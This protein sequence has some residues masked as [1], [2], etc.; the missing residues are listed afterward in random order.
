MNIRGIIEQILR[1][2]TTDT[3]FR[4]DKQGAGLVSG[5]IV[6]TGKFYSASTTEQTGNV[7]SNL[8]LDQPDL[9]TSKTSNNHHK[10]GQGAK[11][12]VARSG[13]IIK[14]SKLNIKKKGKTW[15]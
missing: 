3:A 9:T 8:S 1:E 7:E 11:G 10:I 13:K 2:N 5:I 6:D 14:S 15:K 4:G 12:N